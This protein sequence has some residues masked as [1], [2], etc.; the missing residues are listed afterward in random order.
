MNLTEQQTSA[1]NL[2]QKNAI[3]METKS[4]EES[5]T[6]FSA[7]TQLT[8]RQKEVLDLL[9]LG[10]TN[11]AIAQE[12]GMAVG[13]VKIHCLAIFKQLKVENRTQAAMLASKLAMYKNG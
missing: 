3:D 2:P 11:K 9:A 6:P 7:I 10:K 12:L 4:K 13:T 1:D 5:T 8:P